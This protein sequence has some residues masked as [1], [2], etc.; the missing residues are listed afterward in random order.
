[1]SSR[2][3]CGNAETR[4][5]RREDRSG[6]GLTREHRGCPK[7]CKR[8]FGR[9]KCRAGPAG[10]RGENRIAGRSGKCRECLA[11]HRRDHLK[12]HTKEHRSHGRYLRGHR[13]YG[14]HRGELL[15]GRL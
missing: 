1:M 4:E 8:I 13:E 9:K 14:K 15:R 10:F 5:Y 2:E 3:G 7:E 11:E 6:R 12:E